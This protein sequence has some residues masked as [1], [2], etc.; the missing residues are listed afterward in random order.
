MKLI[1][2]YVTRFAKRGLVHG[3]SFKTHFSSP[4]VSY[5]NAP[6][7][8]V[9]NTAKGWTACFHS[10]LFLK[11][12]WHPWVLGWPLNGPIFPWKTDSWLW[13]TTRLG[14]EFG[15]GFSCFVWHVEVKM[16][17][18]EVIWLF[19]SEDVAFAHHLVVSRPPPPPPLPSPS[20]TF[21]PYRSANGIGY[22][23]KK[24][25]KMAGNPASYPVYSRYSELLSVL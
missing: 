7:T 19:F 10:G 14:D 3:D 11:P 25:S 17:P 9:F 8:H 1:V 16:V 6:T 20:S 12:V 23:S 13:I 21:P 18:M 24:P 22:V 15:H 4:S 5:I 2:T